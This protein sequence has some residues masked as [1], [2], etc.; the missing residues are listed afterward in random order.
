MQV[1]RRPDNALCQHPAEQRKQIPIE[2]RHRC[3]LLAGIQEPEEEAMQHISRS[4]TL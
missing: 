4:I 3:S 2:D 1:E